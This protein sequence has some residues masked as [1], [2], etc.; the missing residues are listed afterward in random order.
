VI[1]VCYLKFYRISLN[2]N[3]INYSIYI[4]RNNNGSIDATDTAFSDCFIELN[5]GNSTS[6]YKPYNNTFLQK[7][8]TYI[9]Y[10]LAG[11]YTSKLI[12]YNQTLKYYTVLPESKTTIFNTNRNGI[13][14]VVFRLTPKPNIQDLQVS[15][16]PTINRA[17]WF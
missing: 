4:D 2:V 9:K 14:S 3:Q 5:D 8:G 13:D 12:S 6:V 7:D 11:N 1:L 17:T 10:L 16:V 15:I